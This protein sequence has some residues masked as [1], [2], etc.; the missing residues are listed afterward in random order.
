MAK[1][2]SITEM[3]AEKEKLSTRAGEIT[4]KAKADKR[5]LTEEENKELG[6]IQCRM[7]EISIEIERRNGMNVIDNAIQE[8]PKNNFSLRKTLLDLSNGTRSADTQ[9]L[10]EAGRYI[11]GQSGI[12]A[13]GNGIMIPVQ[14]VKRADPSFT[15]T[16]AAETGSGLIQTDFMNIMEPLRN[17]LILGQA[18]ATMMTGLVNNIEIPKYSGSQA[19]W[20]DENAPAVEQ[21]GTFSYATM[22]PKRLTAILNISRQLLVQDSLNVEQVLRSDLIN[23]IAEKLELT[24]FG[25][26]EHAEN[27]P[28]GLFTGFKDA[29]VPF[30]WDAVVDMETDTDIKNALAQNSNYVLHTKLRGAAKVTPK[31]LQGVLGFIME[32]DGTMNGY[33][34]L[35]TNSVYSAEGSYGAVFGNWA[36]LLIGQWGALEMIVDPYTKA[37]TN[38]VRVIVNSYWDFLVRRDESFSKR[39]FSLTPATT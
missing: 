32:A 27:T 12:A 26:A 3:R 17:R 23:A 31:A 7:A 18:G 33:N 37:D 16:G 19:A 36:D 6:E 4:T 9:K 22:K 39:L 15:A 14:A 24:A 28:D 13:R 5:M 10:N 35:R 29:A 1:E 34:V 11:M 30:S 21:A 25:G 38:I 2:K 8:K 20:A